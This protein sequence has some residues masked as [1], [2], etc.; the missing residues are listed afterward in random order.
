MRVVWRAFVPVLCYELLLSGVASVWPSGDRMMSVLAS[1]AIGILVF[2]VW[3]SEDQ[4]SGVDVLGR[5]GLSFEITG[6]LVAFGFGSCLLVNNLIELSQLARWFPA[7]RQVKETL[8]APSVPMQLLSMGVV[9]PVA[10]ELVFRGMG[11]RRLRE[12]CGVWESMV[13]SALLFA[14][15]HGNL[16]QGIYAGLLG[17]MMAWTYERCG[18]LWASIL[19]HMAANIGSVLLTMVFSRFEVIGTDGSFIMIT[20]ISAVLVFWSAKRI[21]QE[22]DKEVLS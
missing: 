22:E 3:F 10:E 15:S 11:Y 9:I 8:Y 18:T 7:V 2:G 17:L 19:F 4:K 5:K 14:I 20:M 12:S 13:I 1:A 21:R 16:V 6:Y